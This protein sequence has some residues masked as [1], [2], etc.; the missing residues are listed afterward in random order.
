[1]AC[2][3]MSLPMTIKRVHTNTLARH[4]IQLW[5]RANMGPTAIVTIWQSHH[6]SATQHGDIACH[7]DAKVSH[8]GQT[9]VQCHLC[10]HQP[11]KTSRS[12]PADQM[13]KHQRLGTPTVMQH[14]QQLMQHNQQLTPAACIHAIC[15]H[16]HVASPQ[17]C[18]VHLPT[19]PLASLMIH[20]LHLA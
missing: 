3:C 12:L 7:S 5:V 17:S 8:L 14:N 15:C 20:L 13:P 16:Q 4:Y 18:P 10:K 2:P 6:Q 1:M 19:Q 11:P 9:T